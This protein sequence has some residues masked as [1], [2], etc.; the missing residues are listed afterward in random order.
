MTLVR[1]LKL[2]SSRLMDLYRVLWVKKIG[3]NTNPKQD[4][5]L[6]TT[7]V[8]CQ[9]YCLGLGLRTIIRCLIPTK[10]RVDDRLVVLVCAAYLYVK[11]VVLACSE[12][13]YPQCTPFRSVYRSKTCRDMITLK[14]LVE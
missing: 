3:S 11:Y 14:R 12:I 1:I 6:S 7:Q 10:G 13:F 8:H 2:F 9:Q 4:F 5:S